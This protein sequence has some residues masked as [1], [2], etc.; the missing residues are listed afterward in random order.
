EFAIARGINF[1]NW[2]GVPD[3]L[4]ETVAALGPRRRGVFV[5]VQF[6]ARTAKDAAVELERLLQELRT[7]YIDLLTFYYVE[8]P[9]EWQEIIGPGGA[10]AYCRQARRAG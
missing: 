9:A 6:E 10:L 3:A 5:C 7:D 2:C 4:S 8:A 1:L